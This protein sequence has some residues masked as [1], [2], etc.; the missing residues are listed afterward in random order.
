MKRIFALLLIML[1]MALMMSC[2]DD[3]TDNSDGGSGDIPAEDDIGLVGDLKY[4]YNLEDYITL[5]E[6]SGEIIEIELDDIQR[7]IDTYILNFSKRS[8]KTI[9]MIGDVADVSYIGYL[10]DE[11]GKILSVD[12]KTVTFDERES[13][14]V[15]L[16]SALA[17]KALEAGIVG[18][19]VGEQRDIYVTMPDDYFESDLA[20]KR[21]L[22][23]VQLSAIFEAPLYNDEFVKENFD[24]HKTTTELENSIIL[25]KLYDII[26]EKAVVKEYPEKEYSALV[27]ELAASEEAFERENGITLDEYIEAQYG[28]TRDEY[29]K[30]EIKSELIRYALA[31]KEGVSA[32]DEEML[33]EKKELVSYYKAYYKNKGMSESDAQ[34][35]ANSIVNDLGKSYLYENIILQKTEEKIFDIVRLEKKP[36]TYKS[37]TVSLLERVNGNAGNEIGEI[38]PSFEL[39]VFDERG[40]LSTT[41]NPGRNVGKATVVYFWNN[42]NE[43]QNNVLALL[44]KLAK[45]YREE[46]VVY[47]IHSTEN[48]GSA[49][50][51]L[52]EN[53]AES[54]I[55]F[56]KDYAENGV[57]VI[58][59]KLGD[60]DVEACVL[61]VNKDGII[62][63]KETNI[64]SYDK[65]VIEIEELSK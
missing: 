59:D 55:I 12:G 33:A 4:Q 32:T 43:A 15:Y 18:M 39:E 25:G 22:F 9:C 23:D 48:Y 53:F 63:T 38:L 41:L 6:L 34:R 29:V 19:S 44:D 56:L 3:E 8:N 65:L 50:D 14:G 17:H 60:K 2:G 36:A 51:Y 7:E 24:E 1:S 61:F 46:L 31:Q 13:Y 45:E 21:V 49:A 26:K 58:S 30:S 37:V 64:Q 16:G 54:K 11:N 42:K 5:P 40:A 62:K 20:G 10:L 35:N 47:A 52:M 27:K 57:D 28:M